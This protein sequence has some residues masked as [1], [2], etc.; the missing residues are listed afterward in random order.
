[1]KVKP[2]WDV[3]DKKKFRKEKLYCF[4]FENKF[5]SWSNNPTI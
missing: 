3:E 4:Q 1:M 2:I 5:I